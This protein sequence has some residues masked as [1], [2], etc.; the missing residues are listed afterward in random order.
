[1]QCDPKRG[2]NAIALLDKLRRDI[3]ADISLADG[4]RMELCGDEES[5]EESESR[6]H[7][8]LPLT[9]ILIF[10]ILLLLFGRY[11]DT[12]VV[13]ITIPLIFIGVVRLCSSVRCSTSSRYWDYFDSLA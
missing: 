5:R 7:E 8:K 11:R 2:V 10:L 12:L 9:L 13:V 3:E 4:Y 6:L 1:M